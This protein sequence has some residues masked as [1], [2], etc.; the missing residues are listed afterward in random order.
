MKKAWILLII[1][2]TLI[3]CGST[4]RIELPLVALDNINDGEVFESEKTIQ[5]IPIETIQYV[6]V[7]SEINEAKSSLP[8]DLISSAT[9]NN[10]VTVDENSFRNSIVEYF[11]EDGKIYDIFTSI[12]EV[13]D[14]RLAP[15]EEISG[16]A[17]LGDSASWMM[18]TAIT[19]ES[20]RQTTHI[21]VKP[22]S[23]GLSTSMIIPTN[24]RT[25]YIRLRSFTNLNMVGVRWKYPELKTFNSF[26]SSTEGINSAI[27]DIHI[28]ADN[29]YWAYTFSGDTKVWWKPIA[30]FDDGIHTFIQFDSRFSLT[31]GAP[32]LYLLQKE[33]SNKNKAEIINYLIRG[34]LYITDSILAKGQA[35][36]LVS[37][38]DQLKI[39][40]K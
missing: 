36:L 40:R 23:S 34:N 16:E 3:S 26:S 4:K 20:G 31:S 18:N 14:I 1:V 13:T 19:S 25:Y 27:P 8:E 32:A 2:L 33:K 5:Y 15:G 35:L 6:V 21:Y 28:D 22:I 9:V 12:N 10:T 11:F 30:V 7:E 39:V 17:A 37:D 38:K 24:Q 29:L